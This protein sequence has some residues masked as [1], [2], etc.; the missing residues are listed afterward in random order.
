MRLIDEDWYFIFYFVTIRWGE[1][2]EKAFSSP[3]DSKNTKNS[4]HQ[5]PH[6]NSHPSKSI[7]ST[8]P[9]HKKNLSLNTLKQNPSKCAGA[10]LIYFE[11]SGEGSS[12]C[13]QEKVKSYQTKRYWPSSPA[14]THKVMNQSTT[15]PLNQPAPSVKE[16]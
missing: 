2:K 13:E 1:I 10:P 9:H 6:P 3:L 11:T 7:K 8:S 14:K 4:N 5:D 15:N 16:S 12:W